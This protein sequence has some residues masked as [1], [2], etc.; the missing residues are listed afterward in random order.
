M[1]IVNPRHLRHYRTKHDIS[2]FARYRQ[3]S[4]VHLLLWCR[5]NSRL[6]SKTRKGRFKIF[7]SWMFLFHYIFSCGAGSSVGYG[8]GLD[9]PGIESRWGERFSAPVQTGPGAHPASC[10]MGTVSFPGV[11]SG[12]GVTLTPHPLLVTWS[13]KGRAIPL[14][15][16][17][18]VRPVQN[19]SA[20]TGVYFTF[21]IFT[22]KYLRI[23]N[24]V[25]WRFTEVWVCVYMSYTSCLAIP[26][27]WTCV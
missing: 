3:R 23:C 22:W 18:A 21:H 15:P 6:I 19:L 13:W 14:L 2:S 26:V 24:L 25:Q 27:F 12:R 8:Y 9:G 17:W 10:T 11:R 1:S 5:E 4:I 20:C 7:S 16:L